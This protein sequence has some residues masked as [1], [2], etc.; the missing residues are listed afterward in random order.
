ML[1][2]AGSLRKRLLLH[3]VFPCPLQL[4]L[5]P[6]VLTHP[7]PH[8]VFCPCAQVLH[9]AIEA[10]APDKQAQHHDGAPEDQAECQ[11][12]PEHDGAVQDVQDLERNQQHD[13]QQGYGGDVGIL[14]D[15]VNQRQQMGLGGAEEVR[16]RGEDGGKEGHG[17]GVL[18][19]GEEVGCPVC[20]GEA[21]VSPVPRCMPGSG[22][23]R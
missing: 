1:I 7:H 20:A 6:L 5:E 2:R 18:V 17:V 8:P 14:G 23:S 4:L 21:A 9:C 10:S 22:G 13:D 12:D 16:E 3:L 15:M 11:G 19:L